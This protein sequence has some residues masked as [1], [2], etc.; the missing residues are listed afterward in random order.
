[1]SKHN[2]S[3]QIICDHLDYKEE[4]CMVDELKSTFLRLRSRSNR[5]NEARFIHALDKNE[6][7][8]GAI[9][10]TGCSRQRWPIGHM[11]RIFSLALESSQV[12]NSNSK[13]SEC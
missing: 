3:T 8:T 1:M 11:W 2:A 9:D 4:Y 6:E 13:L 7:G 12:Q 5:P 10:P